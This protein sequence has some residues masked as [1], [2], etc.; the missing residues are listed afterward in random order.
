MSDV[1]VYEVSERI[2]TITL[3]RP[4]ARNVVQRGAAPAP[5]THA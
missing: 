4:E 5:A 3:N 2:A 1:V